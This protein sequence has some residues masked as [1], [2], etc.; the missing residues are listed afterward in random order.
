MGK[1]IYVAL[2]GLTL[3]GCASTI[4]TTAIKSNNNQQIYRSGIPSLLS[5]GKYTVMV[6]PVAT[7][8]KGSARP[9]YVVSVA[10]TSGQPFELDTSHISVFVDGRRLKVFT[11]EEVE[12]EIKSNRQR[13]KLQ[14]EA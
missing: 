8:R 1:L 14:R 13:V 9:E 10:N 3:A 6:S 11:Y 5:S 2:A 7:T 4:Q 12:R